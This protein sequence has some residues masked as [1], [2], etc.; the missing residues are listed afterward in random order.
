MISKK[1][2]RRHQDKWCSNGGFVDQDI[3]MHWVFIR[4][5]ECACARIRV[6]M[7]VSVC[8]CVYVYACV[9]VRDWR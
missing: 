6:C 8:A 2:D 3:F 9:C 5:N 7:F 4:V 1:I